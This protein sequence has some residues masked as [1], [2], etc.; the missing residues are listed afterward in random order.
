MNAFRDYLDFVTK[1]LSS[2]VLQQRL[3]QRR[4]V[5]TRSLIGQQPALN[6]LPNEEPLPTSAPANRA[7]GPNIVAH[8]VNVVTNTVTE[9]GGVD[10]DH[11]TTN[12]ETVGS[13]RRRAATTD[14]RSIRPRRTN[15]DSGLSTNL[16]TTFHRS[17]AT[18][19]P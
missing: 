14:G 6:T 2:R 3:G 19:R 10:D 11:N 16:F 13:P 4:E 17:V 1:N 5:V 12:N 7:R 15:V 8:N 9:P 18:I